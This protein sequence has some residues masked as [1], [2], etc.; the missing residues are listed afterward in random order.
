M[1]PTTKTHWIASIL[2]LVLA[3]P[4]IHG[5]TITQKKDVTFSSDFLASSGPTSFLKFKEF[6]PVL[7]DLTA[8]ALA[9]N[10]NYKVVNDD[11]FPVQLFN[12][13]IVNAQM[14]SVFSDDLMAFYK[15]DIKGL[16][17][18]STLPEVKAG[19]YT[20]RPL[21]TY[22]VIFTDFNTG[23]VILDRSITDQNEVATFVGNKIF[24]IYG[25]IVDHEWK[26]DNAAVTVNAVRDGTITTGTLELIYTYTPVPE[27]SSAALLLTTVITILLSRTLAPEGKKG[28]QKGTSKIK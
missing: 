17:M 1:L 8:V 14:A 13:D 10:G 20:I 25:G 11:P 23:T 16:N 28:G 12:T 4:C 3:V 6:D 18:G 7:G 26:T 22:D 24:K 5:A 9:Y 2:S 21:T 15:D 27:P 19:P